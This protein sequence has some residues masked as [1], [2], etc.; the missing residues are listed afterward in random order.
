[1][2]TLKN[3]GLPNQNI[4]I[5]TVE[6]C[7]LLCKLIIDY[8]PSDKC[9]IEKTTDG[10]RI[11]YPPDS[12]IN[13]RDTSY[14][15]T[16]AYFYYPSRHSIDGQKYDLEVNIYHGIFTNIDEEKEVKK[17]KQMH[18]HYHEDTNEVNQH[19]HFH[20]HLENDTTEPHTDSESNK[21]I[22]TCLLFNKG[23]HIGSDVNIFFN[24]FVHSKEFKGVTSVETTITVHDGWSIE[25]ILPKKR[26]FF[27][28]K[29]NSE[30]TIIV[31]DTVQT[32]SKEII[33]RLYQRGIKDTLLDL[34]NTT[35]NIETP[36]RVFYRK[37]VELITDATYKK[38]KRAQINDLISLTRMSNY[39][40]SKK[41][42]KEYN[43]MADEIIKDFSGGTNTGYLT[44]EDKAKRV[45]DDWKIYGED[46]HVKKSWKDLGNTPGTDIIFNS[47]VVIEEQYL[48]K[49]L[50][51]YENTVTD[52]V[53]LA[54][55]NDYYFN[56]KNYDV[57][58]THKKEIIKKLE[59]TYKSKTIV[60]T[61]FST[62]S[63]F[64]FYKEP[65]VIETGSNELK[66]ILKAPIVGKIMRLR[67]L[68][69]DLDIA[70][71]TK[72]D[73]KSSF[74]SMILEH[75]KIDDTDNNN[76]LTLKE[77]IDAYKDVSVDLKKDIIFHIRGKS[78]SRT[79]SNEECQHWLS[80]EVHYEGDLLK[81][82]EKPVKMGKTDKETFL[83]MSQEL[84]EKIGEGLLEYEKGTSANWTTH[85]KCRNPGN[86]GAAP[87]CYTK[88]PNK[89]WEYCQTPYYSN[90]LGKIILFLVFIFI[91][92]IAFYTI[93]TLFLHEYPMKF[94]A[95]LTGGTL[96]SKDTFTGT[97]P[98]AIKK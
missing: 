75:N 41:T 28:Y 36:S 89:R 31:F 19:K 3:N 52:P 27:M 81:F 93:K 45:A 54:G 8:L 73:C 9:K 64:D 88:N 37:N 50:K 95:K 33:D 87:W 22:V 46:N 42:S 43:T 51:V 29:A 10:F 74:Y 2:S 12:F 83:L 66:D 13:Y 63:L 39:I 68:F 38:N 40:P 58:I 21:N 85:N 5:E 30:N 23:E 25:K 44:S 71:Q 17:G 6:N 91:G 92:V 18:T 78:L 7:N 35:F 76:N 80:N 77:L 61:Y 86:K 67:F 84:K 47:D 70:W 55:K 90:I 15:L 20:Y 24:Q 53:T 72:N 56:K 34:S 59:A 96:A 57:Y 60:S 94:V 26:S 49:L 11:I 48:E 98:P 82:W 69:E 4:N 62:K 97:T 65:L 32:I 16:Y 1:M 79:L 14:E